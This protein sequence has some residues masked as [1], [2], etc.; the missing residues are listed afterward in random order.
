MR[1]SYLSDGRLHGDVQTST[2]QCSGGNCVVPVP[3]P[4]I[5]VVYL[6]DDALRLSSP[7]QGSAGSAGAQG[8]QFETTVVGWGSATVDP[9]VMETSNGQNGPDGLSGRNN[10][11]TSGALALALG[12][13]ERAMMSVGVAIVVG[14]VGMVL[15]KLERQ[16]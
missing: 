3:A 7:P 8:F 2:V 6:S 14:V 16:L 4:A 15:V 13:G 10:R 12:S 1:G 11:A 5:A 9:R